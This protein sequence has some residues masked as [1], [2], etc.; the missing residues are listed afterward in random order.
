MTTTAPA[1]DE[2]AVTHAEHV[3]RSLSE[4]LDACPEAEHSAFLTRLALLAAL[5]HLTPAELD[6]LLADAAG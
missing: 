2:A 6:A 3:W 1:D 4:A 5:D